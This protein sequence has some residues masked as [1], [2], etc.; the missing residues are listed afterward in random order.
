MTKSIATT[1]TLAAIALLAVPPS[2]A[3]SRTSSYGCDTASGRFSEFA[4]PVQASRFTLRGRVKPVLFRSDANY[5][6]TAVIRLQNPQ[7]GTAMAI[8][9]K[10]VSAEAE[11]ALVTAEL[12]KDGDSETAPIGTLAL[13]KVLDFTVAYA[14]GGASRI[15]IGERN[16]DVAADLGADFDLKLSCSTGDFV[17]DRLT[18]EVGR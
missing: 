8:R 16:I 12:W 7:T 18:W 10:A 3:Q 11:G 4:I 15:V 13:G 9:L 5:R 2:S 14:Q 1:L 17:F 6:P